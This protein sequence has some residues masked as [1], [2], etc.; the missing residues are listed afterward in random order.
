MGRKITHMRSI[1]DNEPTALEFVDD[2]FASEFA[3]SAEQE[4]SGESPI[5]I[6]YVDVERICLPEIKD[7]HGRLS[8]AI[9]ALEDAT[10][11]S[12]IP[13]NMAH[14]APEVVSLQRHKIYTFA[15]E[16]YAM[17]H[18]IRESV[19][20]EYVDRIIRNLSTGLPFSEEILSSIV[21]NCETYRTF[22]LS[23]D[24]WSLLLSKFGNY[25]HT[26]TTDRVAQI[27][28]R[29]SAERI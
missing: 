4:V 11:K 15:G 21:Y 5:S 1:L 27:W 8:D 23:Q 10:G 14:I 25:K 29:I 2:H 16:R 9:E 13:L 19:I 17:S 3:G 28:L 26:L 12:V 7:T 24:E 20:Q 6:D 18:R 22:L